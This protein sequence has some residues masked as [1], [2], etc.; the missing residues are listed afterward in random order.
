MATHSSILAWRI[1]WTIHGVAKS[2]TRLSNFHFH[3]RP[4]AYFAR[5]LPTTSFFVAPHGG[6]GSQCGHNC[7]A[8]TGIQNSSAPGSPC[9]TETAL[10]FPRALSQNQ[11]EEEFPLFSIPRKVQFPPSHFPTPLARERLCF[12]GLKKTPSNLGLPPIV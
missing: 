10:S 7:W 6:C 4:L 2:R 11:T 8:A 9:S 1:P 3:L 5:N 12:L